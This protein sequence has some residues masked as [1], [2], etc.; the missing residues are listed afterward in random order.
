MNVTVVNVTVLHI[1]FS[2]LMLCISAKRVE[3]TRMGRSSDELKDIC[4]FICC[5]TDDQLADVVDHGIEVK[6]SNV[7]SLGKLMCL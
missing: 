4:L 1:T 5:K 7:S 3:M 2:V 6:A